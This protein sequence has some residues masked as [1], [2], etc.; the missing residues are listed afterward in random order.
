MT[1]QDDSL[2]ADNTQGGMLSN[3]PHPR[4]VFFHFLFR[5]L[6]IVSYLL[7][8]WFSDYFVLNFVVIVLFLSFDFWTVK[9]VSGRLLVGL[10]WWNHVKNDGTSHWIFECR[11]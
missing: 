4:A 11:K 2:P 1:S 10:R 5:T 8:N 3:L 9:N 6:A 7:C